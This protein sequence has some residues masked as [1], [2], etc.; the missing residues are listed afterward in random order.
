M[1]SFS[2]LK[3]RDILSSESMSL[4]KAG[5]PT[6]TCGYINEDGRSECNVSKSFA[7]YMHEWGGGYWCCDSCAET[8]YCGEK[9]RLQDVNV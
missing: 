5:Y 1:K 8:F 2:D 3:G 7:L 4:I 6:G 9:P